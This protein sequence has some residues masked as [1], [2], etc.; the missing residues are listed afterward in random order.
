MCTL[1]RAAADIQ[2]RGHPAIDAEMRASHGRTDDVDNGVDRADFVEVNLLDGHRM[3]F[4]FGLAEK[5]KRAAC[6]DLYCVCDR[7]VINDSENGGKRAMWLA[8]MFVCMIMRV[9]CTVRM[10]VFRGVAVR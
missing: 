9:D 7:R 4:C 3:N 6:V 10:L 1:N 5:L 2:G 8:V